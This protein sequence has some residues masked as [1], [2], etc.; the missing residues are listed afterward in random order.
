MA[1]LA[2]E[3]FTT[4]DGADHYG[5]PYSNTIHLLR[6]QIRKV[7]FYYCFLQFALPS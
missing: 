4:F 1:D 6:V 7:E 5:K 2:N 3:G